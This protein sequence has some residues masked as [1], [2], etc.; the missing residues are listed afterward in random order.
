[1]VEKLSANLHFS[2][3]SHALRK[4][5]VLS[6][7]GSSAAKL[8]LKLQSP[9]NSRCTGIKRSGRK[10]V[11]CRYATNCSMKKP[12]TAEWIPKQQKK[13][14]ER[15]PH[16]QYKRSPGVIVEHRQRCICMNFVS[17]AS[18]ATRRMQVRV[19]M[20]H[21]SFGPSNLIG[22]PLSPIRI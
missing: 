4:P 2:T 19:F 1:M 22:I 11:N 16:S 15:A 3:P 8:M 9:N 21:S 10:I 5:S 7:C 18:L 6:A 12:E 17:V 20:V 13:L 14:A